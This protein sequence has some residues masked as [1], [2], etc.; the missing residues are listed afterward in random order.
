MK[1]RG[2]TLIELMVAIAV[3]GILS[4]IA[5]PSYQENIRRGARADAQSVLMEASQYME[6]IYSECNS[7]VL[8]DA[9]TTPPCTTA[10]SALPASLAKAPREG[11][12]RYD[13]TLS[14]L[15]A[16]NYV[17]TAAPVTSDGCG[18]FTVDSVGVKSLSGATLGV[19][20]CWRR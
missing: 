1:N 15:A 7:Y 20:D 4:A 19:N 12:K 5:L 18:S 17:L 10:V 3:I 13:I 6:R 11:N 9:S 16:Q 2:F 8:R 14:A